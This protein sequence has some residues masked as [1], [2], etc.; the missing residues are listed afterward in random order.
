[1]PGLRITRRDRTAIELQVLGEPARLRLTGLPATVWRS[2]EARTLSN[3]IDPDSM[4]LCWRS[5][6]HTWTPA[7]REH[8]AQWEDDNDHYV[9]VTQRGAWLSSGLLRRAA[10]LHT[11]ANTFLVDGHR[12]AAFDVARLVLRSSH[13]REQ[14]PGPHNIVA[15][16]VDPVCGLPLLLKRFRGDTDQNY[17]N[18]QQFVLEDPGKTAALELRATVER[19]PSR[20]PPELW[21]AILRR[22]PR[23]GF[24][25]GLSPS[26]LAGFCSL[27]AP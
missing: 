20:L 24:T 9:R 17:G 22:M 23:A 26:V 13:A 10:L 3:W 19:P 8:H 7:E 11:I 6:P 5:S 12:G 27:G 1:M 25:S 16:L 4:Q 18:D 14:G 15:A 2:A 21:Q